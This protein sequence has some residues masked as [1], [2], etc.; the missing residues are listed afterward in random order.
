ML[1]T[2]VLYHW[3]FLQGAREGRPII[4]SLVML[5]VKDDFDQRVRMLR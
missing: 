5:V 4:G 3:V 2:L 1:L